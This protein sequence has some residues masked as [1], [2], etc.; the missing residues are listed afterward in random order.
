MRL[1]AG[2]IIFKKPKNFLERE[3]SPR[4]I[5]YNRRRKDTKMMANKRRWSCSKL[6]S[7]V[8]PSDGL[9]LTLS[10]MCMSLNIAKQVDQNIDLKNLEQVG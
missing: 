9:R 7:S 5:N 6:D 4:C 10:Y 8:I 3:I 1:H 2:K